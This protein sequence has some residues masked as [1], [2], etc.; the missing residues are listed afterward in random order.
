MAEDAKTSRATAKRFFSR[1]ENALHQALDVEAPE[2]TIVRRFDDYKRRWE[3]TQ[4]MHDKYIETLGDV[5]EDQVAHEDMWLNELAQRYYNLEICIDNTLKERKELEKEKCGNEPNKDVSKE[6]LNRALSESVNVKTNTIQLERMKFDR[7]DGSIRK[8]PKFKEEFHTHIKPLCGSSQLPFVLKSYLEVSVREEVDNVEDD[9]NAIWERLDERYG[10]KGRL[11]DSIMADV[12]CLK[13]CSNNNDE[14][15]LHLVKTIEKAYRDL[16]RLGEDEQMNN[17]AIMSTI[18]QKLP[19]KILDE[20]IKEVSGTVSDTR[21]RFSAMMELLADWRK[22][23]EYRLATI[24]SR[25]PEVSGKANHGKGNFQKSGG[26]QPTNTGGSRSERCWIHNYTGDHPIWRCKI[27]QNKP[28]E[29]RIELTKL[30]KACMAC[31]EVGHNIEDCSKGFKCTV[32]GCGAKHN[33]LLHE[34]KPIA[35]SV[36]HA[37]DKDEQDSGSTILPIQ[38]L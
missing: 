19:D 24:R 28:V 1:A 30:N 17:A 7:F 23:I 21:T 29:E 12:K 13:H 37:D 15:T 2:E 6:S 16:V 33:R 11:I 26:K 36:N 9:Y 5:S 4:E 34:E 8:Y 3:I 35:G 31:L 32:S 20:W 10:D 18:E 27:F 22:R 38:E 25:I 14:G